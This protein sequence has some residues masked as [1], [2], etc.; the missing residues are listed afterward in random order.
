MRG[1]KKLLIVFTFFS[2]FIILFGFFSIKYKI[3]G[4]FKISSQNENIT[5]EDVRQALAARDTDQDGLNDETEIFNYYTSI[6]LDDSDSDGYNDKEEVE[7]GSDPINEESNP[8]NKD[9]IAQKTTNNN[10]GQKEL[11]IE[12]IREKL[13]VMGISQE[14]I[15]QVDDETLKNI[16]EETIEETG[17]N[18]KNYSLESLGQVN[19]DQ[20]KESSDIT[21]EENL[22]NLDINE[23]RQLMLAA[24]ADSEILNSVDDET[25]RT[26]FIE[27]ITTK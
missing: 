12:E 17:I 5:E 2:I 9:I 21:S 8:L 19:L 10:Q 24:G 20:I 7:A 3:E 23:I 22:A 1:N 4:P 11:T 16:Y 18:P 25:L 14:I 6:Y 27:A 13:V 26:I 15:D